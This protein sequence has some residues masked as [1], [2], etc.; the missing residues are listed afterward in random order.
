M[1]NELDIRQISA[2]SEDSHGKKLSR[3][4]E[5]VR[6]PEIK[7]NYLGE[8]KKMFVFPLD[9]FFYLGGNEIILFYCTC[10]LNATVISKEVLKF[11]SFGYIRCRSYKFYW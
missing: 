7:K 3:G 8:T 4:N 11:S 9:I 6:F 2:D 5:N 10:H 1:E